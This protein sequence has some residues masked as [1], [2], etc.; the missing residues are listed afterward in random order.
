[1]SRHAC[2][3]RE[4]SFAKS[5]SDMALLNVTQRTMAGFQRPEG[6]MPIYAGRL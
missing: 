1:V 2:K 6:H 5:T 3:A 4:N